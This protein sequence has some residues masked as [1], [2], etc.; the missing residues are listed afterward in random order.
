MQRGDFVERLK[1]MVSVTSVNNTEVLKISV[2][3]GRPEE[4]YQINVKLSELS[5]KEFIRVIKNGSIE[6]VSM[7]SYPTEHTFPS[8]SKFTAAGLLTGL[9]GSCFVFLVIELLDIK[10]KPTDDLMELY[11]IPVFAEIL[12][13]KMING[14]RYAEES[15]VY[16]VYKNYDSYGYK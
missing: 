5:K 9:F 11:D 6:P 2:V 14:S 15:G 1:K 13:F 7:P 8:V 3:S 4:S 10:V 12:D 16:K